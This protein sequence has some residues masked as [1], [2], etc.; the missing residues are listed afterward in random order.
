M[1]RNGVDVSRDD[2]RLYFINGRRRWCSGVIDWIEQCNQLPG[3]IIVSKQRKCH[4][5][6]NRRMG[7]LAA[8]LSDTWN[9]AFDVAGVEIGSIKRRIKK[10]NQVLFAANQTGIYG[11]HGLPSAL[12]I[13]G[14]ADDRPALRQRVDLAF[15]VD[16]RTERFAVIVVCAP[17]SL[18]VPCLV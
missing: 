16:M 4:D 15:R 14:A 3:A 18:S 17:I 6:P 12:R 9:I 2:I 1:R 5:R 13:A 8:I 11:L 7:V 10:L